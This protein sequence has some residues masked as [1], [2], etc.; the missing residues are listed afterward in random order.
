MERNVTK[1][2]VFRL[3]KEHANDRYCKM[4]YVFKDVTEDEFEG[5]FTFVYRALAKQTQHN[6][7]NRRNLV[8]LLR[9][10]DYIKVDLSERGESSYIIVID[11]QDDKSD[12]LRF[13]TIDL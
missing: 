2:E 13:T 11:R 6:R 12:K 3:L 1:K 8:K 4:S 10:I 9:N 7:I 5:N